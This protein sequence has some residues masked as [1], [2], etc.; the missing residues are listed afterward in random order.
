MHGRSSLSE[1]Q[2]EAAV[3]LFE[4]GWGAWA[5]ATRLGVGRGAIKRLYGRWRTR[6][7]TA[8]VAKP[9]RPVFSFEFNLDAVQ[10]YRAGEPKVAP[11]KELGLSS[12]T[13]LQK[14]ARQYRT[15]GEEGLRPKPKGLPRKNPGTARN[16]ESEVER[17]RLENERLRAEVAFLGKVN[18]LFTVRGEMDP[19][20]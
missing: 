5:V 15:E 1:E 7:G 20:G 13:L 2:R 11:A 14:W 18:G 4:T 19:Q 10:R 6:A 9:P 16:P 12:P 17:L 8:L 3:P